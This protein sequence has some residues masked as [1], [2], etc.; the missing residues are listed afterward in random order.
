M[1]Q[2]LELTGLKERTFYKAK[3]KLVAQGKLAEKVEGFIT[4]KYESSVIDLGEKQRKKGADTTESSDCPIVQ[5]TCPNGQ[6]ERPIVQDDC[7]NGQDD[8]PIVQKQELE[9]LTNIV[10]SVAP[11]I[12]DKADKAAPQ[13]AALSAYKN[14]EKKANGPNEEEKSGPNIPFAYEQM[15]EQA[16]KELASTEKMW[17]R[18]AI[19]KR[20]K[21]IKDRLA[22]A[23]SEQQQQLKSH[24]LYPIYSFEG[25]GWEKAARHFGH[26]E[27]AIAE[28]KDLLSFCK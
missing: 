27:D 16:E 21:L 28:F 25:V 19:A 17:K 14:E 26:S 23:K 12:T 7:P 22:R 4:L 5:S 13:S 6:V 11:N 2:W 3:A 18:Q 15:L 8:C 20:I 10:S 24:A 9:P 1:A